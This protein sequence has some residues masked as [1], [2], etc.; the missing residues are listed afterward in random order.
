MF[1]IRYSRLRTNQLFNHARYKVGLQIAII[2]QNR[3]HIFPIFP[4]L[5]W[6]WFSHMT[7]CLYQ[8]DKVLVCVVLFWQKDSC[9][10][11]HNKNT[12]RKDLSQFK[13]L[14]WNFSDGITQLSAQ[15]HHIL[16]WLNGI[17]FV[18]IPSYEEKGSK[19]D[20]VFS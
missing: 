1:T 3:N 8:G 14:F 5:V 17:S 18:S 20:V 15:I 9:F 10:E 11:V 7:A 2:D 12:G 6:D 16:L 13:T 19:Q 4:T